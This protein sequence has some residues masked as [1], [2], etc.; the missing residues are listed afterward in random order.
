MLLVLA[1]R[2]RRGEQLARIGAM[3]EALAAAQDRLS[4]LHD[5]RM[6]DQERALATRLDAAAD[7]TQA[8]ALAIQQRL[9]VIDAARANIEALGGQVTSLAAVLGNKQARG[10]MGEVQLRDLV[11]DRLPA[12]GYAWQHTLSNGT[13]CD[14]LIR[15]PFPPGPIA[16]DSKFPLEAWAAMQ[17]APDAGARNLATRRF[18]Q[19]IRK[20]VGDI[21]QKYLIPGETAE[22]ALM[23]LPS[24]AVH[25]TL[26]AAHGDLVAEAARRGVHIVGPSSLWAVLN[27]MRGLLR[28]ARLQDEAR[29]IRHEVEAL[30]EDTARL[31]RRVAALRG[32]FAN[33]QQDVRDI[34]ITAEKIVRRGET[35]RALDIPEDRKAAE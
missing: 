5:D 35:I 29:R 22:G 2:G 23:F 17:D 15:L 6:R 27:T 25:A 16:V 13:R 26:H 18:T 32:H 14:C 19:D 31:E 8:T 4:S 11:A 34:E 20:H 33:M 3:V 21:S 28:D 12:A 7:R 9:S 30:A 10:A 24:E 1:L